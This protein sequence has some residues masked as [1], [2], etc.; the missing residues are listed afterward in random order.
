MYA[1]YYSERHFG[2]LQTSKYAKKHKEG[3]RH[4]KAD[5]MISTQ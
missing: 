1:A 4:M 2:E 5:L 3:A